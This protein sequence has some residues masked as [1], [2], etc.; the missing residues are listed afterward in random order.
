[1]QAPSA[2]RVSRGLSDDALEASLRTIE[3][4]L[5]GLGAALRERDM[6]VIDTQASALQRA[7][8]SAVHR[9]N[10]AARQPDGVAPALRLRFAAAG[11]Q[12]AAQRESLARATAAIDRAL[13]V[14]MPPVPA[15]SLYG[16]AGH[17]ERAA[18]NG[19][20]RA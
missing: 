13:D 9:F 16:Q 15:A 2:D 6:A 3:A 4:L 10:Q 5:A 20:L 7:L 17:N 19:C 1:M 18:S 8:S 11:A 14:L 12:I